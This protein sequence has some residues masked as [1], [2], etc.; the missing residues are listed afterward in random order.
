MRVRSNHILIYPLI[1][2][3]VGIRKENRYTHILSLSYKERV[4]GDVLSFIE[5]I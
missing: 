4:Y 3:Y 2:E 1:S 5:K